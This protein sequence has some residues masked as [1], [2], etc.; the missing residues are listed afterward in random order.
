MTDTLSVS[1]HVVADL[2]STNPDDLVG[3][4]NLTNLSVTRAGQQLSTDSLSLVASGD[5]TN[6]SIVIILML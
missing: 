6:K 4:V 1:G 3:T 2:P 5:S